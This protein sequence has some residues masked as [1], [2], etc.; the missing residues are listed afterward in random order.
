MRAIKNW[1]SS[2][3]PAKLSIEN[4]WNVIKGF[5]VKQKWCQKY[6]MPNYLKEQ[7]YLRAILSQPCLENKF[8]IECGCTQNSKI[9]LDL[10]C[11]KKYTSS[12]FC[13]DNFVNRKDWE[14]IKEVLDPALLEQ[15][16][17]I[18]EANS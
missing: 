5:I 11:A 3:N 12:I 6:L 1:L 8:C 4:L 17:Q 10:P 2:N 15:G 9:Y 14:T 13:Y 7:V 18:L 16:K